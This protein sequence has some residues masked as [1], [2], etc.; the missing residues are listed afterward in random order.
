MTAL[1]LDEIKAQAVTFFDAGYETTATTLAW[2]A[3]SLA[4]NPDVQE[5]LHD[6][7]VSVVGDKVME[8]V[9]YKPQ[10]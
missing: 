4:V 9:Y 8:H 3:H 2:L 5:K 7:I 10:P 6:E 1:T